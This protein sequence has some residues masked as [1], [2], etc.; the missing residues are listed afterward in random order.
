ML[1]HKWSDQ[2]YDKSSQQIKLYKVLDIVF[3]R[4]NMTTT[5]RNGA[6]EMTKL[7]KDLYTLVS[8]SGL[9]DAVEHKLI[10]TKG[11]ENKVRINGGVLFDS[12]KVADDAE[13]MVNYHREEGGLYPK[14][15]GGFSKKRLGAQQIYV[16]S[17]EINAKFKTLTKEF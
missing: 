17:A 13:F 4:V 8:H 12:F 10:T 7:K 2:L 14:M 3:R 16:P 5:T 11:D 6:N 1:C 9:D 15:S